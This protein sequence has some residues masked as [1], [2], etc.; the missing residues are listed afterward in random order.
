MQQNFDEV[1][2]LAQNISTNGN[3]DDVAD[4]YGIR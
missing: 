2:R 1:K 4:G 3:D